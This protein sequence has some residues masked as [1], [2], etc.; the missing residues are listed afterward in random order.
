MCASGAHVVETLFKGVQTATSKALREGKTQVN[1]RFSGFESNNGTHYP[2]SLIGEMYPHSGFDEIVLDE[3]QDLTH[4]EFESTNALGERPRC[5]KI[6]DSRRPMQTLNPTGFDWGRIRALFI[7]KN[8]NKD[9]VSSEPV[10]HKLPF[11][12]PHR[13]PCK[14]NPVCAKRSTMLRV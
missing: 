14:R 5:P 2:V 6:L 9:L 4:L 8:V 11:S 3:C 1:S 10:P 7:N 12:T 13:Q